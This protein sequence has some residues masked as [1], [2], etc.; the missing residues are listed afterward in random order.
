MVSYHRVDDVKFEGRELLLVVDGRQLRMP[1]SEISPALALATGEE[2]AR[3]V[4]S[5]SGYGIHWPLIDEDVSIDG[6]LGL[7]HSP[8]PWRRTA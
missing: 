1:L 7:A 2:I 3:F 4:V 6:L 5:P 8:Q